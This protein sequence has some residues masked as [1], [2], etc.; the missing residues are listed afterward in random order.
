MCGFTG[1]WRSKLST[2]L[3]INNILR[4]MNNEII[5][6]GPD[7]EGYWVNEDSG[8]GISHRRLSIVDLSTAGKQPMLSFN[9]RFLIAFNGEIY[10]HN[11]LRKK[12]ENE[13]YFFK[14]RGNSDT[15]VF[16]EYISNYGLLDALAS[17][18]GMF[19][20][21]IW[22]KKMKKIFLV[23]DRFGEKPLYYGWDKNGQDASLFFASDLSCFKKIKEFEKNL[24]NK[25][26]NQFLQY[27]FISQP[28]SIYENVYQVEPG[29][30]LEFSDDKS[31]KYL[32]NNKHQKLKWWSKI[33]QFKKDSINL[34]EIDYCSSD[35]NQV[36]LFEKLLI[37]SVI[38]QSYS[39]VPSCV[40]LSGGIDSSLIASLLAS[41]KGS[42]IN[43]FTL[44]FPDFN[45]DEIAFDES[46]HAE[47]VAKFL[48]SNHYSI[49]LSPNQVLDI[50]PKLTDI[51]SE[52]FSDESQIPTYLISKYA[53]ESGIKVAL[54]GDGGD[55]LFGGYNRYLFAPKIRNIFGKLP[56]SSK[57]LIARVIENIP[58]SS[59][60]LYQDK[61]NKLINAIKNSASNNQIYNALLQT[62]INNQLINKSIFMELKKTLPEHNTFEEQLM[63][64]DLDNYLPSNILVKTD[65]ASM[66][67]SMEIRAPFLD[68][69]LAK[70][71][72]E[73]DLERKIKYGNSKILLREILSKYL[74]KKLIN[75]PKS[76]FTI[77]L[78]S[79]LRGPL[80]QWA[81]D[82]LSSELLKKQDYLNYIKVNK[83]WT[84][85]LEFNANNANKI[86]TILM[87]Q[88][89]ICEEKSS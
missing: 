88:S 70:V 46:K 7:D 6:R 63:L 48:N 18:V 22:D 64:G 67:S 10:N 37:E 43:T 77:P 14:W 69:R 75:R 65:R 56:Y 50:I 29:H 25:S 24:K 20:F 83:L 40:F 3:E 42:K 16:L 87:W 66:Y 26:I 34:K 1:I 74:P 27:G 79:W 57:K 54:G 44:G 49:D 76:G 72:F 51:Y 84:D 17:A 59:K 33:D 71:A 5:L 39:D 19:S 80:K 52:P 41:T 89:W 47:E 9:N 21:V 81:D 31:G 53:S 12:I 8:I 15:E 4:K 68:H 45:N 28:D 78:S 62:G 73:L 13:K 23:R 55:E 86:W 11:S 36:D 32:R 61:K 85:H 2:N 38:L 58:L 30:I 35:I 60:G 82:L